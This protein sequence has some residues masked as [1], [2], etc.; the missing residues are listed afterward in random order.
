MNNRWILWIKLTVSAGLLYYLLYKIGPG[1]LWQELS[2]ADWRWLLLGIG[3][4]TVSNLLGAFQWYLLLRESGVKYSYPRILEYYYIGLFF[5]NFFISNMGGDV[6]RF[7][8]ISRHAQNGTAAV[9][10]VFLDRFFGFSML[11]VLAVL[12]GLY[13][14]STAQMGDIWPVLLILM[15]AWSFVILILFNRRLGG[16]LHFVLK[17]FLPEKFLTK[18]K[19]IYNLIHNFSQN[20]RLLFIVMFT[21]LAIQLI[22]VTIH[23]IAGRALGI[24]VPFVSFMVFVP[25]IALLASL[26]ISIGGLGVREQSGVLLF[27]RVGVPMNMAMPMELLAYILTIISSLPG[28]I[29]Y[30]IVGNRRKSNEEI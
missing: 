5:N 28:M 12:G 30:W 13:W 10:T 26:P 8:Y 20:K 24:Q 18:L 4:F 27:K 23:Y 22:R 7:Y 16:M 19:D 2:T 17:W 25:L 6:F 3:V 11:T 14:M 15:A 29:C 1:V 21:S 9:S